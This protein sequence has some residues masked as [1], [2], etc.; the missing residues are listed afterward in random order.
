MNKYNKGDKF[1]CN[2]GYLDLF[3]NGEEYEIVEILNF[4][5]TIGGDEM[6]YLSHN[7]KKISGWA[8]KEYELDI[9]FKLIK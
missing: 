7:D 4:D 8:L 1:I 9:Q 3:K 5:N 6:Y 2:R